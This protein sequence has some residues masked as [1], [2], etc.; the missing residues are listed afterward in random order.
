MNERLKNLY[1]ELGHA[2]GTRDSLV[3]FISH[4]D[5]NEILQIKRII[6]KIII[7]IKQIENPL[8]RAVNGEEE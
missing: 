3:R 8:Y 5:S 2:E 6:N 4:H 1:R 7:E